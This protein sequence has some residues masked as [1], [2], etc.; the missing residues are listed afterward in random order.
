[1]NHICF[2][3]S[4]NLLNATETLEHMVVCGFQQDFTDMYLALYRHSDGKWV[5]IKKNSSGRY[6]VMYYKGMYYC[7]IIETRITEVIDATTGEIMSTIPPPKIEIVY[8][9]RKEEYFV[10]SSGE[11]L[12]VSQFMDYTSRAGCPMEYNFKIYR[13]N[14]E[15]GDLRWVKTSTIADQALFLYGSRGF[16]VR[17][18]DFD[19]FKGNCIYFIDSAL[20]PVKNL[21]SIRTIPV[22]Y[23]LRYDIEDGCLEQLPYPFNGCA[24]WIMPSLR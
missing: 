8:S 23:L 18:T 2:A 3:R 5:T 15:N 10:E 19:R 12:L 13:L 17:T 1:M 20:V 24:S 11:M 4:R 6:P 7:M 21:P 9:S 22:T 14:Q 16:S